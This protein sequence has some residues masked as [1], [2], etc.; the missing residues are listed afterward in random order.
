MLAR[1]RLDKGGLTK[2]RSKV[3]DSSAQGKCWGMSSPEAPS[4]KIG[5]AP[6][7]F[8]VR[9][10]CAIGGSHLRVDQ[11]REDSGAAVPAS[12]DFGPDYVTGGEGF[13]DVFQQL[14]PDHYTRIGHVPTALGARRCWARNS[15][16]TEAM[17]GM[18]TTIRICRECRTFAGISGANART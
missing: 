3:S 11:A 18:G 10:S 16:T 1:Q 12:G 6:A 2:G 5:H 13:V 4:A 15:W 9:Q 8:Y 14:D 17:S 7:A